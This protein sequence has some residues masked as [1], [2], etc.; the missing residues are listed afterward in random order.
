M[1]SQYIIFKITAVAMLMLLFT[2]VLFGQ[3]TE[4]ESASSISTFILSGIAGVVV[5]YFQKASKSMA[6][7][8]FDLQYWIKD[9]LYQLLITIVA[10]V[11]VSYFEYSKPGTLTSILD[12]INL[13]TPY[14]DLPLGE[15]GFGTAFAGFLNE[16]ILKKIFNKSYV[17]T[18]GRGEAL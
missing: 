3:V 10:L 14:P 2:S 12:M 16:I 7:G 8:N 1:K 15:I 9:N 18:N 11:S 6:T 17:E 13:S 4:A 5:W